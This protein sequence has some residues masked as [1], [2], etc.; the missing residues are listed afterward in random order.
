M[1]DPDDGG[2]NPRVLI[3][4][5]DD[6]QRHIL[7]TVVQ[8]AGFLVVNC[9]TIEAAIECLEREPFAILV[10]ALTFP[11]A[12]SPQFLQHVCALSPATRVVLYTNCDNFS[13]VKTA[14]NLGVFAYVEK[15]EGPEELVRQLH[16]AT[17]AQSGV[18]EKVVGHESEQFLHSIIDALPS[19][20]C[21]LDETGEIVAVNKA[22]REYTKKNAPEA[23]GTAEGVNYLAVCDETRDEFAD[24]A[25]AFATGIRAVLHGEQESFACDY[26]CPSLTASG[27]FHGQVIRVPGP[28]PVRVVVTHDDITDRMRAE[29]ALRESEAL[30]RSL[31][32]T[33]QAGIFIV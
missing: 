5:V 15:K 25:K 11:S 13:V 27:W 30:F 9:D 18:F 3:V 22:W 7:S 21:V 19:H 2:S 28:G 1:G 6:Q 23:R 33:S 32:E 12:A 4:D 8:S 14:L 20:L 24:Q 17:T 10:V 16:R 26:A 31:A 29:N